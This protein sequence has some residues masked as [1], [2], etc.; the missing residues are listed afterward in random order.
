MKPHSVALPP[1]LVD[2]ANLIDRIAESGDEFWDSRIPCELY[3]V[4]T[5][6]NDGKSAQAELQVTQAIARI[7]E[8]GVDSEGSSSAP[9]AMKSSLPS[10]RSATD[11]R[12]FSST[13]RSAKRSR[14]RKVG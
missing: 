6:S 12:I 14:R 4:T 7:R 5:S 8:L 2:L 9:M 13:L 3:Y 1:R 10:R 11:P